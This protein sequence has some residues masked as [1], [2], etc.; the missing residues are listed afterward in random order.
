[1]AP[2][3]PHPRNT[4][5]SSLAEERSDARACGGDGKR[6]VRPGNVGAHVPA[7]ASCA[8]ESGPDAA[9]GRADGRPK[10]QARRAQEGEEESQEAEGRAPESQEKG[11]AGKGPEEGVAPQAPLAHLDDDSRERLPDGES[12]LAQALPRHVPGLRRPSWTVRWGDSE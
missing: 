3:A 2:A 6:L 1:M 5:A 7:D 8:A 11:E 10:A 4:C 12:H 9:D